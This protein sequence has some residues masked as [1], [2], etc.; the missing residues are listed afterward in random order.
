[1]MGMMAQHVSLAIRKSRCAQYVTI[2][3][4]FTWAHATT[5]TCPA[6]ASTAQPTVDAQPRQDMRFCGALRF[7][8]LCCSWRFTS[9]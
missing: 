8:E 6:L 5:R 9:G 3:H 7:T 1:M 2:A 4:I